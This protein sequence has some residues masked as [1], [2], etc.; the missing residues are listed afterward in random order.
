MIDV[1]N[2]QLTYY[3]AS[4]LN[5]R[6]EK[7]EVFDDNLR[8]FAERM[9]SIMVEHRGIG[10]AA[11]QAGVSLRL[12]IVS[13]EVSPDTAK[14]YINPSL[15]PGGAVESLE[16]GCLSLPGIY[17]GVKR[18]TDCEISA[19]DLQGNTVTESTT[20]LYARCVQHEFDHLEGITLVHRMG[21]TAKMA[22]RRQLKK[23][24]EEHGTG[25]K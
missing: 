16:E 23:L 7:V 13:L 3:P 19:Q 24:E 6:T 12:F 8:R 2:C 18:Y 4:I 5:R 17:T 11:P 15:I 10:L 20:G 1:E 21:A 25:K 9:I 14:V 22:H